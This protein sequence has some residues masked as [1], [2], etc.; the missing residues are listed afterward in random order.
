VRAASLALADLDSFSLGVASLVGGICLGVA[1]CIWGAVVGLGLGANNFGLV[2][3]LIAG[4]YMLGLLGMN[5]VLKNG[6]NEKDRRSIQF[7]ACLFAIY[8]HVPIALAHASLAIPSALLWTPLL[9]FPD[10]AGDQRRTSVSRILSSLILF[11][12]WPPVSLIPRVFGEY[13]TYVAAVYIPLHLF[14]AS[15]CF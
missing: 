3:T 10:L 14:F 9:A 4:A 13:T 15:I 7:V 6:P 1:A 11:A 2:N 5:R 8:A 12:T